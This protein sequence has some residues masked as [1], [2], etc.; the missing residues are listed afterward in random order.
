MYKV[1]FDLSDACLPMANDPNLILRD[2]NDET[3][4]PA[5]VADDTDDQP[6]TS[7]Y[8]T[9]ARRSVIGN[10]P[11]DAYAPPVAFLQLG[12]TQAHRSVLEAAQ[13]LQMSME[14]K[15]FAT[16]ASTAAPTVDETIHRYD[17]I[18]TTTS[19]EELHAWALGCLFL[20]ESS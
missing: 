19:E 14:E 15:L 16:T 3:I 20:Q 4:I 1:T 17:K 7:R 9:Q 13:L 12:T 6:S 18:M 11:Y 2:P 10:Q 5:F 8:P